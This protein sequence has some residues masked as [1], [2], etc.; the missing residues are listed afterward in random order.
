[1]YRGSDRIEEDLEANSYTV[2]R[3]KVTV[4][5]NGEKTQKVHKQRLDV[6]WRTSMKRIT[7]HH[8]FDM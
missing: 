2:L 1:M 8:R 3:R 4:E 6:R 5:K 7:T